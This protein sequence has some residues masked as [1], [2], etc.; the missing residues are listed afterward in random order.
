MIKKF[1]QSGNFP[2]Y[3]LLFVCLLLLNFTDLEFVT[4]QEIYNAYQEQEIVEKYGDK[5]T[6]EFLEDLDTNYDE[7]TLSDY[8]SDLAFDSIFIF[9]DTL[10][11]PYIA[12]FLLICFELLYRIPDVKF[13]GL[14][15][16]VLVA[17]F[18]FVI[19]HAIQQLYLLV[20]KPDYSMED[21]IYS[22]PLALT[23]L[24]GA[25]T[26]QEGILAYLIE[27]ADLF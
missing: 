25:Q 19:Q 7:L 10:K 13:G 3:L 9:F 15:K 1:Y 16:A 2:L 23:S 6:D 18:V 14:I 4:T 26:P 17:E 8:L 12:F 21:I 20:F 27:Y 5:Y 11:I 24:F 22:K